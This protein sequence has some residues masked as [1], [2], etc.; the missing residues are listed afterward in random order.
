MK[1]AMQTARV[2]AKQGKIKRT[3]KRH[4]FNKLRSLELTHKAAEVHKLAS[5]LC[6]GQIGPKHR[7]YGRYAG[8]T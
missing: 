3:N 5:S 4:I 1:I 8:R 7:P 6:R 2:I